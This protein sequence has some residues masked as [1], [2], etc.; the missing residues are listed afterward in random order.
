[1]TPC[2][3]HRPWDGTFPAFTRAPVPSGRHRQNRPNSFLTKK[4]D[5]DAKSA[6]YS[7]YDFNISKLPL[8]IRCREEILVKL[9]QTN[10]ISFL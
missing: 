3:V 4:S 10:M 1:M 2:G 8:N 9:S 7:A 5:Y 6:P